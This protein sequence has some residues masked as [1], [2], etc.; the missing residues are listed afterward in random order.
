[1]CTGFACTHQ[2]FSS[3]VPPTEFGFLLAYQTPRA[4]SI[5]QMCYLGGGGGDTVRSSHTLKL[6]A[7]SKMDVEISNFIVTTVTIQ[8]RDRKFSNIQMY[9]YM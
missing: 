5:V 7:S 2:V 4:G 1:M 8:M 3:Y 6:S 9:K